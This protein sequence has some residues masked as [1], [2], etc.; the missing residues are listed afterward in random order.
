MSSPTDDGMAALVRELWRRQA[1]HFDDGWKL[2][3][4]PAGMNAV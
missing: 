4:D 2:E 3:D 1:L